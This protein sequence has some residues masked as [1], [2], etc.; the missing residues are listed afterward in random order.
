[1]QIGPG[2]PPSNTVATPVSPNSIEIT[3]SDIDPTKTYG[4]INA[5]VVKYKRID[6]DEAKRNMTVG[7]KRALVAM[8]EE[9]VEYELE[10]AGVTKKGVGVFSSKVTATTLQKGKQI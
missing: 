10:V 8:L 1:M 4:V 2:G 5:Y 7:E 3:W 6:R 9:Y